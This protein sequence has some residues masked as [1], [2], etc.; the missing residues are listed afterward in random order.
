LSVTDHPAFREL[1]KY[2]RPKTKESDIP[3]RTKI[4]DSVLER[5]SLIEAEL[6]KE[7]ERAP[8]RISLTFDGWSSSIMVAYI[9]VTAHYITD[10]WELRAELLSFKDL[11]GS[12]TGENMAEVLYDILHMARI[13]DKIMN[14]TADNLSTNDKCLR[15]L[16][17][18]LAAEGIEFDGRDQRSQ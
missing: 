9:G 2:Q 10:D 15:L 12:H 1:L 8:G 3:H 5:A 7:L 4:T 14:A 18:K 6:A 17:Q 16:S 13:K 11:P